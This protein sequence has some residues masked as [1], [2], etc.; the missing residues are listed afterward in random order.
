[1]KKIFAIMVSVLAL[2]A[3]EMD[4]FRSDTMTSAQLAK[5]P[6]S[7]ELSTLGNYSLF[8][9]PMAYNGSTDDGQTYLKNLM[10]LMEYSSDD[11]TVSGHTTSSVFLTATYTGN[12]PTAK[13]LTRFWYFAY[14]VIFSANS[15]IET[16]K[17]GESAY[18]DH[19]IGENYAMRAVAHLH[20]M[21]MFATP[22]SR[23][24]DKPGVVLRTSTDCSETKRATVGEC[25]DRIEKDFIKAAEL[26]KAYDGDMNGTPRGDKGFL[27]YKAALGFLTRVYLYEEKWDECIATA[28]LLLGSDPSANLCNDLS[29]LYANARNEGEV[30]WCVARDAE[31][32]I[33]GKS[34]VGSMYYSPDAIGG[35]GYAEV[36]FSDPLVEK[37]YRY[38][39]ASGVPIDNRYRKLCFMLNTAPS[40][41]MVHWPVK[42]TDPS[43]EYRSNV[44]VPNGVIENADG[45]L[46]IDYDDPRDG[47]HHA[48]VSVKKTTVNGYTAWYITGFETDAEDEDDITGG[49]RVYVRPALSTIAN[50]DGSIT[51]PGARY[52][53]M[54]AYMS[55]KFG[56]QDGDWA[57]S[58]PIFMRYGEVVLNRAEAYAHKGDKANAIKDVNVIR[59]RAGYSGAALYDESGSDMAAKGF[60]DILD[61]V[62]D[63]RQLELTH[64]GIRTWDI[65]RNGKVMDRRYAGQQPWGVYTADDLD[66]IIPHLIPADE[67]N[68]SHIDQ[69]PRK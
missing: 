41:K 52:N 50:A 54:P 42:D 7:S 45:T 57:L 67:I 24:L 13:H 2:A 46:T 63:E 18:Y 16:M 43:V 27:S 15:I 53:V 33:K 49:T 14:K 9:E 61:L 5:D 32:G 68:V 25:F 35:E 30:L 64:E 44:V 65:Y 23:G 36:Y 11:V 10:Q 58:S 12:D 17:E 69:N 38:T 59:K 55:Y 56:G 3:C 62:L 47:K 8:K 22:P 29:K 28:N 1:M 39:D 66:Y 26:M 60:E 21:W 48:G 40:G 20:L 34:T 37:F 19:I 4:Y 6:G 31:D 51:I